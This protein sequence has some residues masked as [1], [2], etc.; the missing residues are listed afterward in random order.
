MNKFTRK[1]TNLVL[2]LNYRKVATFGRCHITHV[3]IVDVVYLRLFVNLKSGVG[4]RFGQ[5]HCF[6]LSLDL[7]RPFQAMG[8]IRPTEEMTPEANPAYEVGISRMAKIRALRADPNEGRCLVT[9]TQFS[10][11]L[12]HC[13]GRSWMQDSNIVSVY[14]PDLLVGSYT[15]YHSSITS[16]GIGI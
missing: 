16:N 9:N 7:P 10:I 6:L 12:C 11:Q 13:I 15:Y 2:M 1:F 4:R 14:L 3:T 8:S 5:T